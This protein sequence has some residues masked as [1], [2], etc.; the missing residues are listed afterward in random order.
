MYGLP[1][2]GWVP[3]SPDDDEY[4]FRG[5]F[6]GY[7]D[8]IALRLGAV[9]YARY[10]IYHFRSAPQGAP[11][12]ALNW[13]ADPEQSELLLVQVQLPEGEQLLEKPGLL[14]T[15]F[16]GRPVVA[17]VIH[18]SMFRCVRLWHLATDDGQSRLERKSEID[19]VLSKL[20]EADI[21]VLARNGF[22]RYTY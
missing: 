10:S 17:D 4:V 9:F 19:T 14:E 3:S 13:P 12:T 5:F 16:A 21:Q 7:V 15:F 2:A 8:E 11:V 6:E 22:R 1:P 20:T 18:D